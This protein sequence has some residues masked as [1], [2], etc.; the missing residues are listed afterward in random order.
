M[1]FSDIFFFFPTARTKKKKNI[2]Y[3]YTINIF[4]TKQCVIADGNEGIMI[5]L[6]RDYLIQMIDQQRN[7]DVK[8][9]VRFFNLKDSVIHVTDKTEIEIDDEVNILLTM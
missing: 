6:K 4:Y 5:L 2:I 1:N 9:V 7:T 3:I 8:L